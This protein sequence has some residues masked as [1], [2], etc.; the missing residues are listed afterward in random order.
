MAATSTRIATSSK[1]AGLRVAARAA[2]AFAIV[3]GATPVQAGSASDWVPGNYFATRLISDPKAWQGESKN[4]YMAGI[5]IKLEKDFKTYWRSPGDSGLPPRFDWSG[6]QNLK[7]ARV[8]WPAPTRYVDSAGLSIGYKK[9]VIFPVVIEPLQAGKPV[10][11]RLKM[12]FAVCSDICIPAEADLQLRVGKSGLFSRSYASL[13][14]R[15][16]DRVPGKRAAA[17]LSVSSTKAELSGKS[18]YL[19]I[20]ARFPEGAKGA[21]LFVEGPEGFYMA[22]AEAVDR[23]SDGTTRFKVDLTRGDDPIDLKGETLTLTLVTKTAQAE[24]TWRIE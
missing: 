6:S 22:A 23:R 12:E 20:D 18:P 2:A 7:Q 9:E 13:L 14:A 1:P 3:V 24:T 21:D 19:A 4:A 8:L 17:G 5:H 15:F 11:L 16:I 10:E